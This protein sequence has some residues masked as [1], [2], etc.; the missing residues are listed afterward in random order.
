[1]RYEELPVGK[2][3]LDLDNPRIKQY[4]SH[5][6]VITSEAISLALS[7]PSGNDSSAKYA[8]LR[9]SIK[10]NKGIFTPIIVNHI[11]ETDKYVVIEGNTRLKFYQEFK[12][13]DKDGPWGKIMSIV[14]DDMSDDQI[15]AI[16]LQAHMVGARDW[17]PFSKAKYLDYLYNTEHKSISYLKDFCG[18]QQSQILQL[19]DSYND[20]MNFY[21]PI[22]EQNGYEP[23]Q[24]KFSYYVELQ[25]NSAK[26]AL[27]IHGYTIEDFTKWVIEERVDRAES[28]RK[29]A[30]VLGEE[31][32][33]KEFLRTNLTEAIKRLDSKEADL[34]KIAK[35][36]LYD[37]AHEVTVKLRF[38]SYQEQEYLKNNPKAEIKREKL[39]DLECELRHLLKSIGEN[40]DE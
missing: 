35:S 25:K 18:G 3:D 5:Y 39:V 14:Y 26:E 34:K 9:D 22:C 31:D 30:R 12:E 37:L 10:A 2:V 11:T 28:V 32:A 40:I 23:D 27:T 24:R 13:S 1:M 33:K 36:D 7:G 8:A 20:M 21:N 19:I 4:L 17:D 16:R 29:L 6:K 15:H 38:L